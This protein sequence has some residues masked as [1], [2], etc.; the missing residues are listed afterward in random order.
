MK[1]T[2]LIYVATLLIF[3]NSLNGQSNND[4]TRLVITVPEVLQNVPLLFLLDNDQEYQSKT[5]GTRREFELYDLKKGQ[6]YWIGIGTKHRHVWVCIVGGEENKIDLSGLL[7]EAAKPEKSTDMMTPNRIPNYGIDIIRWNMDRQK[8]IKYD[9]SRFGELDWRSENAKLTAVVVGSENLSLQFKNE[10]SKLHPAFNNYFK[11]QYFKPD[12]WQIKYTTADNRQVSLPDGMT[13][14]GPRD[15]NGKAVLVHHQP[16]PNDVSAGLF[17][18]LRK[19][20]PALADKLQ[21]EVPDLR[22]PEP[23][24]EPKPAPEPQPKPPS[25]GVDWENYVIVGNTVGQSIL[26]GLILLLRRRKTNQ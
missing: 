4:T 18:A 10:I 24:P 1:K 17:E 21:K 3:I 26:A 13:V 12:D 7:L 23:K 9:L 14:F 11:F 8:G 22:K 2:S 19:V 20:D 16:D 5:L 25:P 15:T 6:T